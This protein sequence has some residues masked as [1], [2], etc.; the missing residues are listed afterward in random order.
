[1]WRRATAGLSSQV[2]AMLTLLV[3]LQIVGHH[4]DDVIVDWRAH[5]LAQWLGEVAVEFLL[6]WVMGLPMVLGIVAVANLGPRRGW[7]RVVALAAAV[8]MF[9]LLGIAIR[10]PVKMYVVPDPYTWSLWYKWLPLMYSHY[11]FQAAIITVVGEFLRHERESTASMRQAEIDRLAY[12]REMAD[13]RMQVLQAQIEPHF[14]F[15]TLAN[16]RRLYQND[17]IAGHAMLNNLMHYLEVALPRMRDTQSTLGRERELIDAF[18]AVQR[19]RMGRRLSYE[20]DIPHD[21]LDVTVPPM[22]LLTLVENAIKHG[23]TPLPEGGHIRISAAAEEG[24]LVLRVADS[25]RGLH[26]TSGGGTGL[27]NIRARLVAEHADRASLQLD[28]NVPQGVTSTLILPFPEMAN[29]T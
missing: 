3:A 8:A 1:M 25:G 22:M 23:L 24:K 7:R 21:L 12:D 14:L 10:R 29:S 9:T 20:I 5:H 18:L 17:E 26:A 2:W 16:V 6:F 15:N 28:L 11:M 27:A 13:A 4:I 19:I